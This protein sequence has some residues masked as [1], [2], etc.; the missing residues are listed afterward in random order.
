M[1]TV[2]KKTYVGF[3]PCTELSFSRIVQDVVYIYIHYKF[4][5]ID[6]IEA[7]YICF[8]MGNLATKPSSRD[9]G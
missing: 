9:D 4:I 5:D 6:N 7:C 2:R 1:L 3:E 8:D